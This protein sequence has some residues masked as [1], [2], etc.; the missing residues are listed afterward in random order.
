MVCLDIDKELES[1]IETY[2]LDRHYPA[3][4]TSRWACDFIQKWVKRLANEEEKFLFVG[5]DEH[6][7]R[8]ISN[9]AQA[10]NVDILFI[11]TVEELENNTRG[12]FGRLENADKIYVVSYSRTIEILHWIWRHGFQAESVYDILENE[13]IYLQME[14]YRFFV[15]LKMNPELGLDEQREEKSVDGSALVLYEYYYQKQ[16]LRHAL[17]ERDKQRIAEKLFFLAICM[18][19]FLEVEKVL[20]RMTDKTELGQCWEEIQSLF[21]KIR[22]AV[23]LVQQDNIIVYWLDA[24]SYEEAKGFEYLQSRREHSVYFHNAYTVTPCTHPTCKNMF[25]KILQVDDLGYR[26]KRIERKNSPLLRELEG[27]GWRFELISDYLRSLFPM[28]YSPC[29][30]IT[31][32]TPCS[33]MFWNLLGEMLQ[34]KQKTVYL[35]HAFVELH[36]PE[37]S[38]RRKHLEKQYSREAREAQKKE[39]DEQLCFY[40]GLLGDGF[41]RIYMS[42]HGYG[43]FWKR[44]HVHFQV[45]HASWKGRDIQELFCYLDFGKIIHCL[46]EK[47]EINDDTWE[48]GIVPIQDVDHYNKKD[49]NVIFEKKERIELNDYIAY[50]GCVKKGD[51]Y[52]RFKTGDELFYRESKN[53]LKRTVFGG[54]VKKQLTSFREWRE[55]VGGFPNELDSDSKFQYAAY[56]YKAYENVKNTFRAVA[57]VTNEKF[58]EYVDGSIALRMGGEHSY[59]LYE[60]LTEANKKKIGAI[61]D[62]SGQCVCNKMGV[63][64][65]KPGESLPDTIKAVLLS[66]QIYLE[67]L[68]KEADK[69]YGDLEVIDMYQCW[70]RVGYHFSRE[71]YFGVDADYDVGFL[72]D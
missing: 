48:R 47:Q 13:Q 27:R 2:N 6:A 35:A 25:C 42:D 51:I 15:P 33:E 7:L 34:N 71:F 3:Y 19:N 56:T 18:R 64:I 43:N 46:L 4:R 57:K 31:K 66:S 20:D 17:H 49:L 21:S 24:L 40:D 14:F 28:E 53:L 29:A 32:R 60:S 36:P 26:V 58:S 44:F 37:L 45:Y 72:V 70:E 5:M 12:G 11:S 68:R 55:L 23:S 16:R 9:W 69:L 1:I 62:R 10:D 22:K 41:Y 38:V 54:L 65:F 39:L 59:R 67:D 63:P 50:K 8:L 61:I 52:L 30:E